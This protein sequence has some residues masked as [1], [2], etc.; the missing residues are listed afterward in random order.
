MNLQVMSYRVDQ[1]VFTEA[2]FLFLLLH[3][4]ALFKLFLQ[5]LLLHEMNPYSQSDHSLT[6]LTKPMRFSCEA[7]HLL[8]VLWSLVH[9][10]M[11]T[12]CCAQ[13]QHGCMGWEAGRT[14]SMNEVSA[15][16]LRV[17]QEQDQPR[18]CIEK[19]SSNIV[20]F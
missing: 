13:C 11:S 19:G 20:G 6:A 14:R 7:S 15:V 12:V 5:A 16:H 2:R 9:G 4:S 1:L 10:E 3:L 18:I 8:D 17:S